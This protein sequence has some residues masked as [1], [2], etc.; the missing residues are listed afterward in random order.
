MIGASPLIAQLART[1]FEWGRIRYD[2]DWLAP[3][4]IFI[5]VVAYVIYMYRRDAVELGRLASLW[6]VS[7]RVLAFLGL[8]IV[9]LQP[10]WR[11]ERDVVQNSRVAVLVDTSL[12]MGSDDSDASPSEPSRGQQIGELL[13]EGVWLNELRKTHDVVVGR[14]D[15][16]LE[17]IT[18]LNKLKPDAATPR[19]DESKAIDWPKQVAPR[20]TETR[21]GQALRQIIQEERS[22][23]LAGVVVITEGQQNTGLDPADAVVTAKEAR[24]SIYPIGMGST[25]TPINVRVSDL[26]APARAYPAD[27]FTITGLLQ[28]QGMTGKSVKV[29]LLSRAAGDTSKGPGKLEKSEDVV[30]SGDGEETPVKFEL[31]ASEIGRHTFT[32][33]VQPPQQDRNRDDNQREAVVEVVDRKT[34]VL[35]FAGAA[36][37]EYQFVRNLLKRDRNIEV[38]VLL[39]T[40]FEGVSQ[41]AREVLEEFPSL[42]NE[43]FEYDCVIAFDPNWS[44]LT[45]AQVE[46]VERWVGEQAGGLI[47]IG[48]AVNLNDWIESAPHQVIRNLYPIEFQKRF[49][50][51][52]DAL[53]SSR[54]PWPLEFTRDGL[55]APFLW[56]TD[57]Q[58]TGAA[59]WQDFPGVYSYTMVRGSKP[60]ATIYARFSDP[61]TRVGDSQPPY[62]VGHSYGSGRVM[63]VGS[64]ELWRLRSRDEA[65]FEVI[66]TKL[67]RHVTQAR[68]LRGS[69]RG[70]LTTERDR[71]TP[72]QSVDVRARLTDARLD[73][74][75]APQVTANVIG[76]DG[77]LET[78]K[79]L[80]DSTR[81]GNFRGQFTVRKEG[82]YRLELPV[83]E[84]RDEVLSCPPVQ[85]TIPNLERDRVQRNDALLSEIARQTQGDVFHYYVGLDEALGRKSGVPALASVIRD[86][87]RT[88]TIV[89]KPE[90]LWDNYWALSII[91]GLLCVEWL[92]RRLLRLA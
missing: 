59:A 70:V 62:L 25:Q 27:K 35:L 82:S 26:Q 12:S 63:F 44:E 85:V 83:P 41:D 5:A 56:L 78:V 4:A 54:E 69:T 10:Q 47:A 72:G 74:L 31:P 28:A 20:G 14:F 73:P 75:A 7:L 50:L 79:L 18:T 49:S 32:L 33:R 92:T 2:A 84:S 76:P 67:V 61:R 45:S 15:R 37:R 65:Y 1:A 39:Q 53:Y 43:L 86:A 91:C 24:I 9:Y 17:R 16:D 34:R 68:L 22:S 71:Y 81:P 42:Q 66:Y 38:D 60:G 40:G 19:D 77:R 58:T 3:I 6:L 64:G 89:A 29:E 88:E 8:L 80:P 90:T 52:D 30:L 51:T 57:D 11:N 21:L 13:A 46:L 87:S 36:S 23:P 55:E 48:G